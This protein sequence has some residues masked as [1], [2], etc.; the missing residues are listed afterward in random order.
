MV[1]CCAQKTLG[2]ANPGTRTQTYQQEEKENPG[3]R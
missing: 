1:A 3:V 2:D